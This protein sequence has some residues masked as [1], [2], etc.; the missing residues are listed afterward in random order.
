[1]GIMCPKGVSK[2]Q[3]IMKLQL[4]VVPELLEIMEER[5][6]ILKKYLL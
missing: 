4:K 6:N 2:M 1:M 5:Y 3:E